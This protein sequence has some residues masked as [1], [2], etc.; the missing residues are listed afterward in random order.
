MSY[1]AGPF[2]HEHGYLQWGGVLPGAEIWSCGLRLG[3]LDNSIGGAFD[4]E[5]AQVDT[6][7]DYYV[8]KITAFHQRAVSMISNRAKLDFVKLNKIGVDGH[9]ADQGNSHVRFLNPKIDGGGVGNA[10]PNQVAL[11]L[12]LTTDVQRGPANKGRI[13]I[14]LPMAVPAPDGLISD[15]DATAIMHSFRT[16]LEDISDTP[17]IDSDATPDVLVMS[18]KAGSPAARYVT[19]VKVGRVLDTQRRRRN[20]IR[21]NYVSEAV[22]F[23]A[24]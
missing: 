8:T 14:P 24:A 21:E 3:A 7:L 5:G 18:R 20:A 2:S 10:P 4:Y 15:A 17:G 23:G 9:Y 11:A 1:Q 6:L 13:Y 19:G 22:D 16:L 12:T